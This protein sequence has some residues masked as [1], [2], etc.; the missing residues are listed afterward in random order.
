MVINV[1]KKVLA[2]ASAML[3]LFVIVVIGL[4]PTTAYAA[5]CVSV[6]VVV[7]G[8]TV[9]ACVPTS[10]LPK[11][12]VTATLPAVTIR[13]PAV[14]VPGPIRT[15]TLT[16]PVRTVTVNGGNTT[17]T[18]TVTATKT[19]PVS[20]VTTS[21]DVS[22]PRQTT[23]NSATIATPT[24]TGTVTGATASPKPPIKERVTVTKVQAVGISLLLV[25]IGAAIGLVLLRA[26]YTYGWIKGDDGN[27]KF[28]RQ[29]TDD[30]RYDK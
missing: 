13:P 9:A 1:R 28:I 3:A 23:P 11:V 6:N 30:L 2:L 14:T 27:R 22:A 26:A 18:K 5:D 29:I 17:V 8:Q 7:L 25:L 10:A 24:V 19:G 21:S 16:L 20:T 15:S 4:T 12:T